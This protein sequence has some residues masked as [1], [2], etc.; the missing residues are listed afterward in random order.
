MPVFDSVTNKVK[1]LPLVAIMLVVS[2]LVYRWYTSCP[3]QTPTWGD[4]KKVTPSFL[5]GDTPAAAAVKRVLAALGDFGTFA[6]TKK[7]GFI[8]KVTPGQV[9]EKTIFLVTIQGLHDRAM[10]AAAKRY[11]TPRGFHWVVTGD[12][13]VP[14]AFYPKF[15]NDPDRTEKVTCP[16]TTEEIK[17]FLKWSGYLGLVATVR[18]GDD[19]VLVTCSKNSV[20]NKYA[21]RL[22]AMVRKWLTWELACHMADH[23]VSLAFEVMTKWDATHGARVLRD[24]MVLTCVATPSLADDA[25]SYRPKYHPLEEVL[26]F[27]K[28]WKVPHTD[29]F[30]VAG[31]EAC[32]LFSEALHAIRDQADLFAFYAMCKKLGV[33]VISGTV[34]HEAVLG[35]CLEGLVAHYYSTDGKKLLTQ[36]LKFVRYVV[37]T[38]ALRAALASALRQF[39]GFTP[40]AVGEMVKSIT[41]TVPRWTTCQ[42]EADLWIHRTLVALDWAISHWGA[43][44]EDQTEERVGIHIQSFE[45]ITAKEEEVDKMPL[46]SIYDELV[47]LRPQAPRQTK[48]TV[49]FVVGPPGSGKTTTAKRLVSMMGGYL[50]ERDSYTRGKPGTQEFRRLLEELFAKGEKLIIV[51]MT[52]VYPYAMELA[53]KHEYQKV[54]VH[55]TETQEAMVPVCQE[56]ILSRKDH[57]T[58]D[59]MLP[60]EVFELVRKWWTEKYAQQAML[61]LIR[62]GKFHEVFQMPFLVPSI[63]DDIKEVLK[64]LL[65]APSRRPTLGVRW[66]VEYIH[67]P[68]TKHI[69]KALKVLVDRTQMKKRGI[70]AIHGVTLLHSSRFAKQTDLYQ[71][72]LTRPEVVIHILEIVVTP[73][74]GV[75]KVRLE[76]PAGETLDHLVGSGMPHITLWVSKGVRPVEMGVESLRTAEEEDV[77][78]YQVDMSFTARPGMVYRR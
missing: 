14:L 27:A 32:K 72:L 6:L 73:K 74:G 62:R 47:L 75:A 15:A 67:L 34:Q 25:K 40:D 44:Q 16:E 42:K 66:P 76:T 33:E 18:L 46:P 71:L 9:G 68:A 24:A 23:Q 61:C 56:R 3:V 1:M 58:T 22:D 35:S 54:L 31:A 53:T 5:E 36:K 48:G 59:G 50:A 39:K 45:A 30:V 52:V 12:Q 65:D 64:P 43:Y 13:C 60:E 2:L 49:L 21:K 63:A 41:D 55:P 70:F 7:S 19:I 37:R 57:P 10:I 69:V 77:T 28:A 20:T 78:T 11:G 26:A 38:M 51:S 29:L 4:V 17:F 8:L